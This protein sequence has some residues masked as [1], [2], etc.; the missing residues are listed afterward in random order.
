MEFS[1]KVYGLRNSL[2]AFA[3]S[4]TKN[5]EDARD[6][7]QDTTCRAL[8]HQDKFQEG[9]NLKAWMMT[10]MR[11][12]FINHYR[13]KQKAFSTV[14]LSETLSVHNSSHH[15]VGNSAEG[16]ILLTE[17]SVMLANLEDEIRIPFAMH[18]EGYSYQ[19]IA[20]TLNL[21]LGTV[22]SRI[23]FARKALKSKIMGN[24]G[25]RP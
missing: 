24:Y 15:A 13:K 20:D 6:L 19:E 16:S 21:P 8:T 18:F 11:N 7:L 22:K 23:F 17:V 3:Y 1:H 12:V 14:E 10:I 2:Q 5:T 4:L 25:F 9:T